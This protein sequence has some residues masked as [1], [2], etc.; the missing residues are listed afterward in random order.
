MANSNP[1]SLTKMG[2]GCSGVVTEI[3][4][5]FGMTA[6]L[7]A[8]GIMPGKKI[9]KIS[10]MIGQGPITIEVDRVQVAV[11]FRMAER[12]IVQMDQVG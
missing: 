12:I 5:G 7:N 9:T 4:G 11:G 3:Q 8:L 2:S 6:R 10:S 1:T